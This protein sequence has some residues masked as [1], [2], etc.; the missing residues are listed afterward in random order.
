MKN[1]LLT[2]GSGLVGSRLKEILGKKY[3]VIAPT[4]DELDITSSAQVISFVTKIHPDVIVHTAA[5]TDATPA[6]RQRG[7]KTDLCWKVNVEGTRNIS[8]VANKIGAYLIYISTGS[9]FSGTKDNPGPFREDDE[10]PR[11]PSRLSWYGWTKNCAERIILNTSTSSLFRRVLPNGAIIRISHPVKKEGPGAQRDYIHNLFHLWK[12]KKLYPLFTDQFF[13]ITWIDDVASVI[14]K[15]IKSPRR[16]IFHVASPDFVSPYELIQWII[17]SRPG[18]DYPIRK[19]S[20]DEFL[21][22]VE[23]S[24]RFTRFYAIDSWKT[25]ELLKVRFQSWKDMVDTVLET[26]Q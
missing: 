21:Q 15:L 14:E 1:I 3:S 2:G 9:V 5:F 22:N 24:L 4:S 8:Q 25:Q 6:E 11:D 12:Q 20:M 23:F 26:E 16:G 19:A 10:P 17:Q 7:D 13:P 18:L